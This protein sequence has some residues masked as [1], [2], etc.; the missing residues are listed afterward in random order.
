M[1]EL[2]LFSAMECLK[3]EPWMSQLEEMGDSSF[4]FQLHCNFEKLLLCKGLGLTS[5]LPPC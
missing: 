5:N 2:P 1:F 4:P 3:R